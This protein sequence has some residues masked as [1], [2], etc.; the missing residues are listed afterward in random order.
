MQPEESTLSPYK[1][2]L[3]LVCT[4]IALSLTALLVLLLSKPQ[5]TLPYIS[6]S[7]GIFIIAFWFGTV[8]FRLL[9]KKQVERSTLL[10][11]L[12]V[13]VIFSIF[14]VSGLIGTTRHFL[15]NDLESAF[16]S[17]LIVL[18]MF[19]AYSYTKESILKA[20]KEGSN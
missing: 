7:L 2:A 18:M 20:T 1:I 13:K 9:T 15:I 16:V 10:S 4:L 3:G 6:I 19:P 5:L 12:E 11:L 8:A 14:G 17:L